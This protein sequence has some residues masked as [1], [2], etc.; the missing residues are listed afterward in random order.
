MND[1]ATLIASLGEKQLEQLAELLAPRLADALA[2]ELAR[3]IADLQDAQPQP[4]DRIN[5]AELARRFGVSEDWVYRHA[6]ELG[7]LRLGDGPKARLRFH[8]PTVVER[9]TSRS[10]GKASQLAESPAAPRKSAPARRRRRRPVAPE[11]PLLPIRG[12]RE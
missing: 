6:D 1:P 2:P 7:A 5:A 3:L 10:N 11:V 9:L 8:V 12:A 4:D